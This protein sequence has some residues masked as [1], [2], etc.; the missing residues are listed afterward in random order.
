MYPP[1]PYNNLYL[2]N[3]IM[4]MELVKIGRLLNGKPLSSKETAL[5]SKFSGLYNTA[6]DDD[7]MMGI[8][9]SCLRPGCGMPMTSVTVTIKSSANSQNNRLDFFIVYD[10]KLTFSLEGGFGVRS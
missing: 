3:P 1:I 5:S 4:Y 6:N 8:V 10:A 7:F 9:F 2:G